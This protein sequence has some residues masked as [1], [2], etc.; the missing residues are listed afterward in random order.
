MDNTRTTSAIALVQIDGM[1]CDACTARVATAIDAATSVA[2]TLDLDAG[3]A[4]LPVSDWHDIDRINSAIESAGYRTTEVT[5]DGRMAI[6]ITGMSC[7]ACARRVEA[8]LVDTPGVS[9]ADIAFESA[10]GVVTGVVAVSA[11]S[12]AIGN[13]GYA[14]QGF[15]DGPAQT[16]D[17]PEAP[18]PESASEAGISAST[19][20]FLRING[21]ACASCVGA[22]ERALA[23]VPLVTAANV[24]FAD[25]SASVEG[26]VDPAA[27]TRAIIAAGY[28]ATY[29]T[30]DTPASREQNLARNL[31][32]SLLHASTALVSGA[33]LMAS[34]A[35]GVL[36]PI[37]DQWFWTVAGV[38]TAGVMATAGR[39]FF[40]GAFNAGRHGATTMDTLIALGTS[41]AW[42]FSMLVVLAPQLV[43]AMS[44]HVFFEAALFIIGF[45]NLGKALEERARGKSSLAIARLLNLAPETTH[46][47]VSDSEGNVEGVETEIPVTQVRRS[48]RLRV[49]PGETIPVDAVITLGNASINEAMLTG[50]PLPVSR[51]PGD[52]VT[53]GTFN[54]DGSLTIQAT[55]VGAGSVL[56]RMIDQIRSAQNSKPQIARMTDRIAAVFVPAVI[57]IAVLAG[58]GWFAF[59]PAPALSYAIVV[60]MSVL[61]IACPCALGLAIP[62]S[63]MTGVSRAAESGILIRTSESLQAAAGLTTLVLD[64]TGTITTGEPNVLAHDND[65]ILGLALALESR[66]E[67][68]L[69]RAIT[70]YCLAKNIEPV[71][72]DDFIARP[73]Q[74][75]QALL[76][77]ELVA[78][79]NHDFLTRHLSMQGSG[80]ET[81]PA[82]AVYVGVGAS[83]RGHFLLADQPVPNARTDVMRLKAAGLKVMMLTGDNESAAHAIAGDVGI[84][85]VVANAMPDDKLAQI[86]ALQAAGERVGMVGD[87][88]NDALALAAADVGFAVGDG[89]DVALE[90][91]DIALL[92]RRI[93]GA[94][95]AIA[96]SRKTLA[97]IYQNLFAAFAY[98][99]ILIPVAAGAIYPL[100]G[101]LISPVFAGI[102][103]TASSLTVVANASRLRFARI[104]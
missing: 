26:P 96:L 73:G 78:A 12:G 38:L 37:T 66:S 4:Q 94:A 84:E 6:P 53:G 52:A 8:A 68:P 9:S 32:R 63:I 13:A 85:H 25:E 104:T 15:G 22:V 77:G 33:A 69:G 91:A 21:M 45:I 7:D 56:G 3:T 100:L 1:H 82:T 39:R 10:D 35:T 43:P 90:S 60:F 64:K 65:A 29:I 61:I 75:V 93:G 31:R 55:E 27:L 76:D 41:T 89:T 83:I 70:A 48:D 24:N 103:M 16:Q 19:Q 42:S 67:H 54:L 92:G 14:I 88:I 79:G 87:G 47:L 46:L 5:L 11:L 98:N 17:A 23:E 99:I 86:H 62:M 97:N 51:A 18:D 34:M 44:H 49:Y 58:V 40:R 20:H 57:A 95:D 80:A 36:P 30:D 50:E 71:A 2:A 102:A 72:V 28:G 101:V 74:G 59:G 81:G